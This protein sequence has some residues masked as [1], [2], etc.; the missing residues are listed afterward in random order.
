M[1]I[2]EKIALLSP[3]EQL[4]LLKNLFKNPGQCNMA[5]ECLVALAEGAPLGALVMMLAGDYLGEHGDP[6]II[7]D[8]EK[9]FPKLPLYNNTFRD[10]RQHVSRAIECLKLRKQ[11]VCS[12]SV[13][14]TS[15]PS[16]YHSQMKII[17]TNSDAYNRQWIVE[18]MAC[19]QK[20]SCDEENYHTVRYV[21]KIY[22]ESP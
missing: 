4:H 9:I 1:S 10:P 19:N 16:P 13:I 3:D 15:E 14:A 8:L 17:W 22:K 7:P 12:C 21:W 6:K 2:T 18:C 20:W 5:L 11:N